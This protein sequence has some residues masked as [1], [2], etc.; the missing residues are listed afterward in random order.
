MRLGYDWDCKTQTWCVYR[1]GWSVNA[2]VSTKAGAKKLIQLIKDN[3]LP[4]GDH[5]RKCC[6]RLLSKEE[7]THLGKKKDRYINRRRGAGHG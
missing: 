5:Y 3:K 6:K 2:H 1:K 7:Y 4:Y